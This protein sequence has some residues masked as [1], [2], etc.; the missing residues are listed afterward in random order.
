MKRPLILLAV[1][2]QIA[3]L[4]WMAWNR[5]DIL[6]H[7]QVMELET[8]PVDPRDIFRGDYVRLSYRVSTLPSSLASGDLAEQVAE[9]G[10]R[11]YTRVS[12]DGGRVTALAI[13]RQRPEQGS[14]LAG[15]LTRSWRPDREHDQFR[16]KYGIEQYFVEQGQGLELEQRRRRDDGLQTPLYVKVAV[17][18]Q[19]TAVIRSIRWGDLGIGL[20]LDPRKADS[21]DTLGATL[22]LENVSEHPLNLLL[23]PGQC[24]FRLQPA[25][26]NV[27]D[28][29]LPER[30]HCR[31]QES[32]DTRALHLTPGESH[33]E[34]F[35]FKNPEWRVNY[36]GELLPIGDLPLNHRYRIVYRAPTGAAIQG[37]WSGEI[38]SAAFHARGRVD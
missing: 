5:E 23:A 7:G 28:Q 31:S 32:A 19:G 10:S 37:A 16:I 21:N 36:K 38:R 35:E 22:T 33:E 12:T 29:P 9:R 25:G 27:P 13:S 24:S 26:F 1:L 11:V 8:A 17:G 3:A 30:S 4:L 18:S 15:R 6:R 34:R 14:Y 20:R 2:F